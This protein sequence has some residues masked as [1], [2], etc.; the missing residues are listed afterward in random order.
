MVCTYHDYTD[1]GDVMIA[2]LW[3]F[4]LIFC[5]DSWAHGVE[6]DQLA[7]RVLSEADRLLEMANISYVYGGHK[8][9]DERQCEACNECL[10]EQKPGPKQRVRACPACKNCSLDCSHFVNLVYRRAGISMGYLTTHVMID[11][12][13][14]D[15]FRLY[16]LLDFAQD[17]DAI[18]PADLLVYR[19]HV[20]MVERVVSPGMVD[21]V[22]ATG[23][24]DL[25]GPGMGIQR[26]RRVL[27]QR[28]RGPLLRILRPKSLAGTFNRPRP[29]V[30]TSKK[31]PL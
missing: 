4:M 20:V 15:L 3:L 1:L 30:K 6:G 14:R 25:R 19:G 9:S 21:I 27:A 12:S 28:F 23:G 2:K 13:P 11:S 8:I 26:E 10:A 22:H 24:R 7:S 31:S 29:S 16:G 18:K 5:A 17:V